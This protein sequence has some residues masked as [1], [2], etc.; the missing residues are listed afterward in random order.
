MSRLSITIFA[1]I[2][3]SIIFVAP[4]N[5]QAVIDA[6]IQTPQQVYHNEAVE[7]SATISGIEPIDGWIFYDIGDG[8]RDHEMEPHG[9]TFSGTIPAQP[10]GATV[11]Y[12][13]QA[14]DG[15]HNT[16]QSPICSYEVYGDRNLVGSVIIN[17]HVWDRTLSTRIEF[18]TIV[19]TDMRDWA[20][21]NQFNDERRTIYF[22]GSDLWANIPAETFIVCYTNPREPVT[23]DLDYSDGNMAVSIDGDYLSGDHI[24]PCHRLFLFS[25][26]NNDWAIDG[27]SLYIHDREPLQMYGL[28]VPNVNHRYYRGQNTYSI[29]ATIS[30]NDNP[31]QWLSPVFRRFYYDEFSTL[32]FPNHG[33]TAPGFPEIE[34]VNQHPE[35]PDVDQPVEIRAIITDSDNGEIEN[36]QL[37][38]EAWDEWHSIEMDQIYD[39]TFT[40]TIP[41]QPHSAW[42]TYYIST[43]DNSGKVSLS[44]VQEY[45][46]PLDITP[47][48]N[49]KANRY[50]YSTQTVMIH[51]IVICPPGVLFG[52]RGKFYVQ[53]QSGSGISISIQFQEEYADSLHRGDEVIITAEVRTLFDSRVP[54]LINISDLTVLATDQELPTPLAIT[55][56]EAANDTTFQYDATRIQVTGTATSRYTIDSLA[57]FMVYFQGAEIYHE[58]GDYITMIGI[59]EYFYSSSGNPPGKFYFP[60]HQD[61]LPPRRVKAEYPHIATAPLKQE[62]KQNYPNPFNPKTTITFQLAKSANVNLSI[63]NITGQ[64]VS[65]LVNGK[66]EGG[67]HSL[68][69]SSDGIASGIYFYTLS[70]NEK[71]VDTKQMVMLK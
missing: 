45:N 16:T 33:Q 6:I 17:E 7:I 9:Y 8:Y 49:I 25:N 64:L 50:Q 13:I 3:F 10:E 38:Y 59:G 11:N 1:I 61:D 23:E 32:G 53:D 28:I 62:L 15:G 39:D 58:V 42:V 67:V 30:N 65:T 40:A 20:I 34:H 66:E 18:Y 55:P 36:A 24:Y 70:V 26:P 12:Y 44:A 68:T 52:H 31:E 71:V 2:L 29:K 69:F 27:I 46:T 37:H 57:T 47:I 4:S 48:A 22:S 5:G 41:G 19:D 35:E 43:E 63:Y 56:E 60:C 51:G 54:W 21:V 14:T